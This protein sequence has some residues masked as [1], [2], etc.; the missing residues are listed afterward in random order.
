[1]KSSLLAIPLAAVFGFV[2]SDVHAM[3]NFGIN[4]VKVSGEGVKPLP[5]IEG[6]VK[7]SAQPAEPVVAQA[8][9]ATIDPS[10]NYQILSSATRQVSVEFR[11]RLPSFDAPL[12]IVDESGNVYQTVYPGAS[13]VSFDAGRTKITIP[14]DFQASYETKYYILFPETTGLPRRVSPCAF[15]VRE[16]PVATPA[17]EPKPVAKRAAVWPYIVGALI[18]GG[19]ACAIWCGGDNGGGGGGD[20]DDDGGGGDED[21]GPPSI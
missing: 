13:G 5:G 7:G 12:Y 15:I 18:L 17:P 20:D 8:P 6:L 21:G 1:M 14:L 4:L 10:G 11:G 3:P 2:S 16:A 19:V 9:D